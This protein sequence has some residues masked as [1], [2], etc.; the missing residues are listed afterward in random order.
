MVFL[1]GS[2][3]TNLD[4]GLPIAYVDQNGS[5]VERSRLR[6]LLGRAR[7][8][9][10]ITRALEA[11]QNDDGG[12][13]YGLVQGRISAIHPTS[14][15]LAWMQDLGLLHSPIAERAMIYLLAVQRPEGSWDEP[16][17][18]LRYGPLPGLI[19]GDPRVRTLST[20]LVANWLVRTGYDGDA[21]TRATAYLR[22]RQ[23]PDGR[24]TGFLKTT[25]LAAGLFRAVEG[26][27]SPVAAKA[28]EALARVPPERWRPGGLAGML[29]SLG[30]SGVPDALPLVARSVD[31]L[32]LLARSDGSW[33]SE[34]G[35]AFH[36]DVTLA[37]LRALL[38]YAAVWNL[39]R[40]G[41]PPEGAPSFGTNSSDEET[42]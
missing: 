36:V 17:G 32:R 18:S 38:L 8:E 13:P 30:E 12:F 7:P 3:V 16:P 2:S 6:G 23:A 40:H 37:V 33:I 11:R 21:L 26:G 24:F 35:P 5:E 42:S 29:G 28:L 20:A 41:I 22:E 31:H 27:A 19:P 1:A 10:K 9:A 34:D 25:W 4:W 15:V 39:P 14:T